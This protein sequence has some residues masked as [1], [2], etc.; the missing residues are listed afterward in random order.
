MCYRQ[1]CAIHLIECSDGTPKLGA[2][3]H[4]P[5]MLVTIGGAI[6]VAYHTIREHHRLYRFNICSIFGCCDWLFV[7]CTLL[8]SMVLDLPSSTD[9]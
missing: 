2:T 5:I 8:F 4:E 6:E 7:F 1:A 3:E 9:E